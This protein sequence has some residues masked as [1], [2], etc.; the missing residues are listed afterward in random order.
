MQYS[1]GKKSMDKL[2]NKVMETFGED[3]LI[4]NGNWSRGAQMRRFMSTMN[5]GLRKQTH[6]KY[7]AV[8]IN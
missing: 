4:G 7:D 8:T 6:K 3:V 5:K 1:Y 2:L